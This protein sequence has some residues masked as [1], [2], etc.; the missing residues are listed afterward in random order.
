MSDTTRTSGTGE[1]RY[2]DWARDTTGWLFGLTGLAWVTILTGGLPVLATAGAGRWSLAAAMLPLWAA[3]VLAVAV[4]VRGRPAARWLADATLKATGDALGWTSWQSRAAAG[5][6]TDPA[7]ADLPG[8]LT[9]ISV[10]DGPPTGPRLARPG[11]VHGRSAGT[12]ALVARLTH[13]GIGLA[14]PAVRDR[15]ATGLADV[16]DG[17]ATGEMVSLISLQVRTVPDDGAERALWRDTHTRPDAPALAVHAENE[18]AAAII[19][20][21]VRHEVF[22]TLAVPDHRLA[23]HARDA[24]GG[25]DGRARVLYALAGEL[26]ARLLG[27]VGCSDVTWLDT[28]ALAAAIRTGFAPGDRPGLLPTTGHE[29]PA[30]DA[31]PGMRGLPMSAAGPS[32]APRPQI[33]SYQHDAWATVTAAVLPPDKGAI[34]GAL[35]PV[36]APAEPGER[37]C[38]T[39]F[40]EP[41]PRARADRIVGRDTISADT[42]AAVRHRLGFTARAAQRRD[43]ARVAGQ[44]VR[45]AHG[46]ALV[47]VAAVAAVTVPGSWPIDDHGQRLEA[48]IRASGFTP[49]RLDLAQDAAFAAACVPLGIGMPRHRSL[50]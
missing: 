20:A 17:A 36:L 18:L 43:A 46:R 37:R 3:V 14:E 44:D 42:A 6:V 12:W 38:L 7:Q 47:R 39:V 24:G 26:E 30:T 35:A 2:G 32:Q 34:L 1:T 16:L 45:L 41:I 15:M 5:A 50:G 28:P 29:R 48:A 31:G 4:P 9:G 49:L 8:V 25:I 23:R 10:Y 27:P 13:P 40:Y 33:R 11:I 21:G 19:G 22:V